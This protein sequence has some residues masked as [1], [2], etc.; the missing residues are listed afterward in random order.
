MMSSAALANAGTSH[1]TY[2]QNVAYCNTFK[3]ESARK[4]T[5]VQVFGFILFVLQLKILSTYFLLPNM[6]KL[7]A[8]ACALFSW[9]GDD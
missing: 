2:P 6:V 8:H 5:V 7:I 1:R 3:C 9:L 4:N